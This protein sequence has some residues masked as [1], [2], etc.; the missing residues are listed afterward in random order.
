[1]FYDGL[2]LVIQKL[3]DAL[4]AYNQQYLS[5][6]FRFSENRINKE[7]TYFVNENLEM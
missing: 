6:T 5:V 1:M 4:Y 3:V 2:V 7:V